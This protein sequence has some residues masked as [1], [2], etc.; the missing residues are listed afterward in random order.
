MGSWTMETT[1]TITMRM[2]MTIAT[3]G[4]LMKNL[5][6]RA[7]PLCVSCVLVRRMALRGGAGRG[8]SPRGGRGPRLPLGPGGFGCHRRRLHHGT[9]SHVLEAG[10]D[11]P[12]AGLEALGDDPEGAHPWP[13]LDRADLDGVIRPDHAHLELPLQVL[14]GALRHEERAGLQAE[15]GA[16]FGIL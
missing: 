5:D 12:F 9:S 11:D 6:M 2:E 4:R 10:N 1:P 8:G 14:H 7:A 16:H 15:G 13:D 3:M